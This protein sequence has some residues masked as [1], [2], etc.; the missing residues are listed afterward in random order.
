M[1][2][3][4][5]AVCLLLVASPAVCLGAPS[6]TLDVG[7][8]RVTILRDAFG[9]PHV[10]ASTRRGLFH[11]NGYAVAEDR[12][13]QMD[14]KRRTARGEMAALVGPSAVAADRETRIDGYTE[15]EREAQLARLPA[16]A[17]EAMTAYADGVNAYRERLVASGERPAVH[18]YPVPFDPAALRPWRATDSIAVGQ[19][20]ARRFGGSEGGEMR[21]MLLFSVLRARHG[22]DAWKLLND[23]A[24]RNDPAAPT[25]IAPGEDGRSW[26]GNPHWAGPD[27]KVIA[28]VDRASPDAMLA[29]AE[30]LDQSARLALARRLGLFERWGSYCIV[31]A[32]RRS[33]GGHAMLVGG[34]QMGFH[35]PQIAHEVHLSGAGLHVAGMGFAGVPGV[36]IGWNRDLAWSTTTGVNDQTDTFVGTLHPD[37]PTRY[38]FRG[39]WRTMETREEVIEVAGAEPV[40][41]QVMR[42]VHGPVIQVDRARNLAY[43]RAATY[44][45]R[46][47]ETLV[48]IMRFAEARTIR[49]FGAASALV[50]TSH[51]FFCATRTGDIGFWFCGL[52]PIR[53]PEV[54][55]RL[56]TPGEGDHEWRGMVP[57][58][59]MPHIINPRSGWIANWN[60]KPAVWWDCYD[61]PAW[62]EVWRSRRL[63]QLLAARPRV[64][65]EDLRNILLDIGTNDYEAQ[66]MLPLLR[67]ALRRAQ[68]Q[69]TPAARRAF[70][71][72]QAWDH[73]ATEGSVAAT[74]FDEWVR[75]TRDALFDATFGFIKLQ[76]R[77]LFD[78]AM[79][80][81]LM[82]R[83][84]RGSASRVPVQFDH[85]R[86]RT[87]DAVVVGAFEKAVAELTRQRG[88][89]MAE[90]RLARGYYTSGA[91]TRIPNI[92]RGTYIQIAEC[93]PGGVRAVTICP[94]GQ[95]E[96]LASPHFA[97]QREMAGWFKFKPFPTDRAEIERRAR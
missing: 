16:D 17:R 52:S 22:Q 97:D 55:P 63:R 66:A 19:M 69:L 81:S 20:M 5:R 82:L 76:G 64:S 83:V 62:G 53:H 75:Q 36:L 27:G 59:R 96:R 56:P 61:T 89:E 68:P 74:V 72:L 25:T 3:L 67:S 46:E 6:V 21:N 86:G 90:W 28:L 15:A 33:A 79:Q 42:T 77:G 9:V 39:A 44:W 18:G 4:L 1:P 45:G 93:L 31:V 95:S 88:A 26:H 60:C 48:A 11:G 65:A 12:L 29:A 24:W 73:N 32:G 2:L 35:T 40:R 87:P 14:L 37:D 70:G 10:F 71:Y 92:E 84:L 43:S 51:N 94:P 50:T 34:P 80:P 47:A 57:F 54:D 13:A 58:D 78:T 85:L 49:E 30:H 8:D 91:G 41:L 7:G 38:R 23:V